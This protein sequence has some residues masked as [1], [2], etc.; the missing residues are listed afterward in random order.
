M[1]RIICHDR[2]HEIHR[3]LTVEHLKC[4]S[5]RHHDGDMR[6]VLNARSLSC[7]DVE[8]TELDQH[9]A[10]AVAMLN[11]MLPIPGTWTAFHFTFLGGIHTCWTAKHSVLNF[12]DNI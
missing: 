1:R 6:I 5:F 3:L 11:L 12:F 4:I 10:C 8:W 2:K 7:S 9:V